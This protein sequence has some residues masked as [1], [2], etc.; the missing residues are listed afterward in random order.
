MGI[1]SWMRTISKSDVTRGRIFQ[2]AMELFRRQGFE[3]TTMRE[4]AAGAGVAGGA[5]YYYFDSKEAIVLAFYSQAQQ[6]IEALA[7]S[8]LAHKDLKRRLHALLTAKLDY[9]APNRGL[10]GTLAACANPQ[11]PLSPFG[12]QTRD[13]RDHDIALF[14]RALE[15]TRVTV[16]EDLRPHLPHLLWMYQMGVILFWIYDRSPGQRRTAVLLDKSIVL[17]VRLIR[18]SVFPLLRPLRRLVVDMLKAV[19]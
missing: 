16:P 9:F 5:A 4:I 13:I 10:L 18:L 7:E 12:E 19:E 15:G 11:H 14:A 8:A 3:A 6:E 2:T 1:M 17:V